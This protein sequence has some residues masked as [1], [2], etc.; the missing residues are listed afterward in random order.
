MS[1][2]FSADAG[3][4]PIS[5]HPALRR[6]CRGPLGEG[7]RAWLWRGHFHLRQRPRARGGEGWREHLDWP[8]DRPRRLRWSQ[9]RLVLLH[10]RRC[11]NLYSRHPAMGTNRWGCQS[12][13]RARLH[14]RPLLHR[15]PL[16]HRQGVTIGNGCVIG[17]HSLVLM[18][19]P[20]GSKAVGAPCRIIGPAVPLFPAA[21]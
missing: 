20:A 14:R 19:V 15:P 13:A 1:S 4:R 11:A 3:G 17:A 2:G 6:L 21:K 10:L 7:A 16:R 12:R 5:A 8:L 18:D 9:H